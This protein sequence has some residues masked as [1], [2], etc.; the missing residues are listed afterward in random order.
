MSLCRFGINGGEFPHWTVGAI[1]DLAVK[2]RAQFVELASRRIE[3]RSGSQR[4]RWA[5]VPN[6]SI[7]PAHML[8][9]EM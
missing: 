6:R 4:L 1:C 8:W 2:V 3:H 7:M 9:M 5:S